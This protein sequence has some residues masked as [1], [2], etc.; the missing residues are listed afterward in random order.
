VGFSLGLNGDI[1]TSAREILF[2]REDGV[3][4]LFGAFWRVDIWGGLEPY[5]SGVFARLLPFSSLSVRGA[6]DE[7]LSLRVCL[8]ILD[9]RDCFPGDLGVISTLD[10][11]D[12]RDCF[13]GDLGVISTLDI[14][15]LRDCFPG[16]LGVISTLDILD[17]RDCF[18]GD[19]TVIS[20]KG[21]KPIEVSLDRRACFLEPIDF[22]LLGFLGENSNEESPVDF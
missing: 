8:E 19:L 15:D 3:L 13:P 4:G 7:P 2:F 10:I 22:R 18:S 16:D 11:L 5:F 9:L 1:I 17:L 6:L 14:L 21:V 20:T 12:L